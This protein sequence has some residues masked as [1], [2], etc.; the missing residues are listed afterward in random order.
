SGATRPT[1]HAPVAARRLCPC[2][3]HLLA[4]IA[5]ALRATV[6]VPFRPV[7][8]RAVRQA[9]PAAGPARPL[10]AGFLDLLAG[11]AV[12]MGVVFIRNHV[13]ERHAPHGADLA[14]VQ[15]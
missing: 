10:T 11:N 6:C 12:V 5:R 7:P 15:D 3:E 13:N 2:W 14:S 9:L 1:G 4:E 8:I